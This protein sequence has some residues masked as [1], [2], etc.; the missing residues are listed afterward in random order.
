[1]EAEKRDKHRDAGWVDS[2]LT[3]HITSAEQFDCL[4][5]ASKDYVSLADGEKAAVTGQGEC[6]SLELGK[7]T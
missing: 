7:W 2:G 5:T 6:S 1:M 4:Q 3:E